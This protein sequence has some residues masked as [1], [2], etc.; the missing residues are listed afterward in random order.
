MT[1]MELAR[2][3]QRIRCSRCSAVAHEC[4]CRL[5]LALNLF[6]KLINMMDFFFFL[7]VVALVDSMCNERNKR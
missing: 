1:V 7:V 2:A 5:F 4:R 6:G 3:R